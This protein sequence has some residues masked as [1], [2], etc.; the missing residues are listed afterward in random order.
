M[1]PDNFSSRYTSILKPLGLSDYEIQVFTSLIKIGPANYRVLAKESNVPTG[2]IY[3]VLSTLESKGFIEVVQGKNKIFKASEPKKAVRRRLR[4]IEDNYLELEHRIGEK[5]QNLQFEYNQK[6]G[7]TQGIVTDVIVGSNAFESVIKVNLLKAG[8]EVLVSS[9]ELISRLHLEE[10]IKDLR[11]KGVSINVICPSLPITENGIS[12]RLSDELLGLGV[13]IRGLESSPLKY[14]IED[15]LNVSLFLGDYEEETYVQ[16]QSTLL[17]R[18]LRES[19]MQTW[20]NGGTLTQN[21][22]NHTS[23]VNQ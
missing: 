15:N 3:Q 9:S 17:C 23:N 6:Y 18:A 22:K 1:Q 13:N 7:K 16:I 8:N 12:K 2:K 10:L 4:E 5:I 14:I 11:L 19:F 21:H 20:K